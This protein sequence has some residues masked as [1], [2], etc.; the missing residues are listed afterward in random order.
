MSRLILAFASL[1]SVCLLV[2]GCSSSGKGVPKASPVTGEVT[3]QG[4]AVEG[5]D[6]TFSPATE[7]PESRAAS[8]KTD[9]AG[10]Y[11]L[12]TYYDPQHELTG[13]LPGEYKVTVIKKQAGTDQAAMMEAMKTG[14]PIPIPKDLL[15]AKYAVPT[16]SGLIYTVLS[17]EKNELKIELTD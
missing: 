15:P 1:A 12:K 9:A 16:T 5:A 3:Y 11:S 6:V 2:V 7:K 17:N 8:G 14:K 13:A 10:K 4:K